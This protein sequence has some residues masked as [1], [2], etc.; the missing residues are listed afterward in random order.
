MLSFPAVIFCFF[1][2]ASRS[3]SLVPSDYPDGCIRSPAFSCAHCRVV[4]QAVCFLVCLSVKSHTEIKVK[5]GQ[6]ATFHCACPRAAA[7]TLLEW[8]RHGLD[9]LFYRNSFQRYQPES[10]EDR[11]ELKDGDLTLIL[12]NVTINDNGT[13]KCRIVFRNKNSTERPFR[14][15]KCFINLTV[16]ASDHTDV[17]VRSGQDVTLQC[18]GPTDADI[19]ALEWSRPELVSE[20]YVFFFQNQH[21]DENYQHESIKGRVELRDSSTKDGDV[22]IILRNISISDTGIYECFTDEDTNSGGDEG[23]GDWDWTLLLIVFLSVWAVFVVPAVS[24]VVIITCKE[25]KPL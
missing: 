3:S 15:I 22:S 18:R 7:I 21:S 13:Y 2:N 5:P 9:S 19:T 12:K 16:T 17:K 11:V 20:G 4:P 8:S 1:K 6:E 25:Q 23:G 14:G 10:F 24:A